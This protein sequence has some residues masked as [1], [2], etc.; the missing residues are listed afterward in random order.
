MNLAL[1]HRGSPIE[2]IGLPRSRAVSL[3]IATA[4]VFGVHAALLLL[5]LDA[6]GLHQASRESAMAVRFI[7]SHLIEVPARHESDADQPG[8]VR[9]DPEPAASVKSVEAARRESPT[10]VKPAERGPTSAARRG[11]SPPRVEPV[12]TAQA[13]VRSPAEPVLAPAP[14]YLL[15]ARL[16]P[17]P[18]P[19]A[20]IE[21]E[22][23]DS[24][25]L[26]EGKVVLRLLISDAGVVDDV[27][28]VRAEP[29]GLFEN[30]ALDA[31]RVARFSPGM[32]LGSPV[33]SQITVEVEFLPINRGARI[34]GRMY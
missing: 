29:K 27:A 16:D 22:Y 17:G 24:A 6:S 34:S 7:P 9:R 20:S 18:R 12:P 21:P 26:Q 19:L 23:P 15:G 2:T 33:K 8:V 25:N 1:G 4:T 3:A 5:R 30:A 11:E 10:G 31:F 13:A 32:V 28:V 14:D